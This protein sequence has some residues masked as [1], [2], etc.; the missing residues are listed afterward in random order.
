M[1]G[2]EAIEKNRQKIGDFIVDINDKSL[3]FSDFLINKKGKEK[4]G[5]EAEKQEKK[6]K[7]EE[8]YA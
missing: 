4:I 6:E 2:D 8:E 3:I 1:R 5:E 7:K